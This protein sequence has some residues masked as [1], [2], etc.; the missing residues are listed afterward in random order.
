M[1]LAANINFNVDGLL[2]GFWQLTIDGLSWGA[3]YALVAV[4]YTLVFGV[5]GIRWFRWVSR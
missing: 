2:N 3:I 4:G 5:I 1:L